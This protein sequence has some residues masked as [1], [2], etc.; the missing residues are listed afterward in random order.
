LPLPLRYALRCLLTAGARTTP[1]AAPG[2]RPVAPPPRTNS[3]L[4]EPSAKAPRRS[5]ASFDPRAGVGV[6]SAMCRIRARWSPHSAW[7]PS[8]TGGRKGESHSRPSRLATAGPQR[9]ESVSAK[10]EGHTQD[11]ERRSRAFVARRCLRQPFDFLAGGGVASV[12]GAMRSSTCRAARATFATDV[13]IA[14]LTKS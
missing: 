14:P 11:R 13:P 9:V 8:T 1:T 4:G 6:P 5:W 12:S 2:R 3:S 10:P 7:R